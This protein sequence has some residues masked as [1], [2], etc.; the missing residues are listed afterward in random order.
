MPLLILNTPGGVEDC[1]P[2]EYMKCNDHICIGNEWVCDGAEDCPDGT[3]EIGCPTEMSSTVR[4]F[5]RVTGDR[6]AWYYF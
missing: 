2:N 4:I 6:K 5:N 1:D 3:D